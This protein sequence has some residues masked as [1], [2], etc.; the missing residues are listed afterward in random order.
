LKRIA[1]LDPAKPLEGEEALPKAWDELAGSLP[2]L[3]GDQK[4]LATLLREIGCEAAGAPY[5]IRALL[6][7]LG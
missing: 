6:R 2:T 4:H 1:I 3:E 7:N 5:V